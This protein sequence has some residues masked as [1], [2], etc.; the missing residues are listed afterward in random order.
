MSTRNTLTERFLAAWDR[1][2]PSDRE[3]LAAARE[4]EL[5]QTA[6]GG[7]F[8]TRP[9]FLDGPEHGRLAADMHAV[10]A[11][12]VSLPDRLFDGDLAA[13]AAATGA[14]GPQADAVRRSVTGAPTMLGRADFYAD[15]AGFRLLEF[16]LGSTVGGLDNAELNRAFLRHPLV[17]EFVWAHRLGF[18]DTLHDMVDT[19]L[20]ECATG[21]LPERP[22]V[23]LADWPTSFPSLRRR[24][25]FLAERMSPMGVDVRPCHVGQLTARPDGV[26]LDGT[27]VD[28]VYR[29]FMIEDLV[30]AD[31]LAVVEPVLRAAEAGTVAL[32]TAL[33]AELYGSK[34]ALAMLSDDRYQEAFEPAERELLER[35]LPWTRPVRPGEVMA[36]GEMV[37]LVGYA[38]AHRDELVLKPTLQHGGSG[39]VCG[40]TVDDRT[41]HKQLDGAAD[42]PFVLQRRIRPVP[43]L[44]PADD[45]ASLRPWVLNWGAF[46]VR[47]GYGGAFLRGVSDA[48]VGVVGMGVGAS[49]ACCF[50]PG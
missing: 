32:F 39:V 21:G 18:R 8:L 6:Y 38:R 28:I 44:F 17:S 15:G 36:G 2:H 12:L 13:F 29:L 30:D 27:R 45:E 43:E 19:M 49:V 24:L 33:D 37:S 41:W 20:A 47:A 46:L 3:L 23:A 10:H 11:L 26:F 35:F 50:Q 31:S 40:W 34:G 16:N 7:R 42:G 25:G 4:S 48:D 5:L 14:T 22:V 1:H 9:A